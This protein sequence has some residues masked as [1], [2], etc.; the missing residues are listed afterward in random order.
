V[1]TKIKYSFIKK[2]NNWFFEATNNIKQTSS[3][4]DQEKEQG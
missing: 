1:R 4:N 3:Q 2:A